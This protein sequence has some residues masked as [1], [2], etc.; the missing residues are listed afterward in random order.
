[1]Y[2]AALRKWVLIAGSST[3]EIMFF[4]EPR[5]AI[6]LGAFLM[7]MWMITLTSMLTLNASAVRRV[8]VLRLESSSWALER[9]SAQLSRICVVGTISTLRILVLSGC[10]P[11]W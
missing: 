3:C 6:T 8:I 4:T 5:F 9:L 2:W 7:G 11:G 10:L 1:M